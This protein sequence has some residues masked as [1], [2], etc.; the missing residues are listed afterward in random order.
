MIMSAQNTMGRE[1]PGPDN[2]G[3]STDAR[4]EKGRFRRGNSGRKSGSKNK[5]QKA[6]RRQLERDLPEVIE[7]LKA[8]AKAGHVAAAIALMRNA[9]P[10]AKERSEPIRFAL[11][12]LKK[13]AD[14][15]HAMA[16]IAEGVA[17][18]ALSLDDAKALASVVDTF[19]MA[20]KAYDHAAKMAVIEEE[21][22]QLKKV[23]RDQH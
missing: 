16:A 21:L 6:L 7:V 3:A 2:N 18:G 17:S 1:E 9:V 13:P 19:V 14:A 12:R 22:Q 20:I 11:P 23:Q 5:L 15:V 10:P 8:K 4:D